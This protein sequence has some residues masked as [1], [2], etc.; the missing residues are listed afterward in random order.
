MSYHPGAIALFKSI[1][2]SKYNATERTWSFEIKDHNE[3]VRKLRPLDIEFSMFCTA[4]DGNLLTTFRYI[5]YL[6]AFRTFLH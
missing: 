4:K 5:F 2:S 3:L 1:E 6:Y